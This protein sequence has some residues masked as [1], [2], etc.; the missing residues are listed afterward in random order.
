MKTPLLLF[1]VICLTTSCKS[2]DYLTAKR[3]HLTATYQN[4]SLPMPERV[5]AFDALLS[6]FTSGVRE[7]TIDLYIVSQM[8]SRVTPYEDKIHIFTL[9]MQAPDGSDR[10]ITLKDNH[11]L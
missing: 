2:P 6:T 3:R 10:W 8:K 7:S 9:S 4:S 5:A 11:V 1:L